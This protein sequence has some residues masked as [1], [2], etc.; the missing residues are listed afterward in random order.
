M[1]NYLRCYIDYKGKTY[2]VTFLYYKINVYLVTKYDAFRNIPI[3]K[4]FEKYKQ[5]NINNGWCPNFVMESDEIFDDLD[6]CS[7]TYYIDI[8]NIVVKLAVNLL[9]YKE[10]ENEIKYKQLS[11]LEEWNKKWL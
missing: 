11:V 8:A 5:L 4:N 1:D 9:E 10:K 2:M 6:P 3:L 7:E